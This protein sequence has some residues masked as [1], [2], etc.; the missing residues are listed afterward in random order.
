MMN[1]NLDELL[2]RLD[3]SGSDSEYNAV[4]ELKNRLGDKLP[5]VLFDR[6]K[7]AKKWGDRASCLY[8]SI[9][10]A[11]TV[12]DAVQLGVLALQDKS[13]AVRYRACMLLA[14]S[15]KP[16]AL[17]ALEDARKSTDR[18]DTF[19]DINAA[20]DAIRSQNSNFFIDRTHSGKITLNV[21]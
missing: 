9:R 11:R 5:S 3:G 21:N 15:L 6:Y 20:I 10:Y 16:E 8:H 4:E 14:Y 18:E 2:N 7:Q 13:K 12:E 1:K 17:S 19:K